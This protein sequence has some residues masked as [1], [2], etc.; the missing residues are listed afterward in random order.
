MKTNH[1]F[2]KEWEKLGFLQNFLRNLLTFFLALLEKE[3]IL[4]FWLCY[5]YRCKIYYMTDIT[6]VW[7]VFQSDN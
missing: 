2:Q 6:N 7:P 5:D 4:I 1:Q 3:P